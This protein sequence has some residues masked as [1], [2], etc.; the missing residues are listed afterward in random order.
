MAND[1]ESIAFSSQ[2]VLF[3][4]VLQPIDL[5]KFADDNWFFSLPPVNI[6]E[7]TD[8]SFELEKVFGLL[9]GLTKTAVSILSRPCRDEKCV[10]TC[11]ASR[12]V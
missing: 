3:R 2:N 4:R 8:A 5:A 7:K 11:L 1:E 10:G 6:P 9:A 12:S